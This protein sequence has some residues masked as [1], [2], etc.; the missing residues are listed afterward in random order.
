MISV[1]FYPQNN[2]PYELYGKNTHLSFAMSSGVLGGVSHLGEGVAE[3][4]G[5]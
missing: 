2:M 5:G 4:S 3:N 1:C